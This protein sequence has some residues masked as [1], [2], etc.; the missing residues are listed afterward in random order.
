MG[1][2]YEIEFSKKAAKFF[3]TQ[4]PQQQKKLAQVINKLP[5]GDVKFLKG[6]SNL[7]RLKVGDC[8]IIFTIDENE[9]L[10]RILVIGNRGDVYKKL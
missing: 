9:E 5:N 7:Y 8:R 6:Y 3:K 4:P 10:I 2:N 1:K